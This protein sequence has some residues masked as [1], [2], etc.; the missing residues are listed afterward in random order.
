MTREE[1]DELMMFF[2]NNKDI[3]ACS[4]KD[5]RRVDPSMA[6]HRLNIDP[7]YPPVRQKKKRFT[8]ERNKIVSNEIDRQLETDAIEPCQYPD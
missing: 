5:I 4:H 8:P 3:F 2:R 7:R 6:E 1:N